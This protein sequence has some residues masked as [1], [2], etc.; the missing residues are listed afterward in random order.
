MG[1]CTTAYA[2][3]KT[4]IIMFIAEEKENQRIEMK[5]GIQIEQKG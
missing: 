3:K 4:G 2:E 1:D 5:Q